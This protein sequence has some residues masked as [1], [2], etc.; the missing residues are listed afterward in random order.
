MKIVV[1]GGTGLIG[2]KVVEKLKQKGHEVTAAAPPGDADR[3]ERPADVAGDGGAQ[4]EALAVLLGLD[5]LEA[6]KIHEQSAP[7]ALQ[8]RRSELIFQ[9][10][11]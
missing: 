2:S 8:S 10:F 6:V 3:L 7:L 11:A 1:I 4:N 9:P 5:L